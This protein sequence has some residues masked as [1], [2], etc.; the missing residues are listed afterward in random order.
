MI[1]KS[2]SDQGF[3]LPDVRS[4]YSSVKHRSRKA[5]RFVEAEANGAVEKAR[6]HPLATVA[7]ISAVAGIGLLAGMGAYRRY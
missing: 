1:S 5:A 6:E 7:I 3:E 4:T 2:L